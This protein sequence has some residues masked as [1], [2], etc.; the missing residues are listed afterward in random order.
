MRVWECWERDFSKSIYTY[1]YKHTISVLLFWRYPS[2]ADYYNIHYIA[3]SNNN[4]FILLHTNTVE[5]YN[6][7][8]KPSLTSTVPKSPQLRFH[9]SFFVFISLSNSILWNS[10]LYVVQNIPPVFSIVFC[11][12]NPSRLLA[13]HWTK[14][15]MYFMLL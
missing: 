12:G 5:C 3:C 2:Y 11:K 6:S 8:I 14:I 15:T 9:N 10:T 7:V 1:N 13:V 4:T